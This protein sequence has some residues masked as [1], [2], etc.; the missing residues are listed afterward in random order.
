MFTRQ[1]VIVS[2][3]FAV[4]LPRDRHEALRRRRLAALAI[5]VFVLALLVGAGQVLA[6]RGGAP[7]STPTVR[8]AQR[9]IVQ[10]GETLWSL[11]GEHHGGMSQ[12]AYLDRLV[13]AN[14]GSHLEVGQV[15]VLP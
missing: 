15:V 6:N 7:A 10:P 2:A 14:N 8:P 5:A 3:T 12:S 13:T 4:R 1:G 11:A 9:H